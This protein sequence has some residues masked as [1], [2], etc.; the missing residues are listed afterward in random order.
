MRSRGFTLI[1][2]MVVLVIIGLVT[3]LVV[4]SIGGDSHEQRA[5]EEVKRAAALLDLAQEQAIL[6]GKEYGVEWLRDGY[7][8]YRFQNAQWEAIE[9]DKLFRPRQL[10]QGLVII[11]YVEDDNVPLKDVSGAQAEPQ[12]VLYSSG[13]RTPFELTV[14]APGSRSGPELRGK[15]FGRLQLEFSDRT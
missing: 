15:S 8:F 14:A 10:E 1:E 3:S 6:E 13:E 5:E 11:L 12:I 4:V 2:L 9:D 7:R